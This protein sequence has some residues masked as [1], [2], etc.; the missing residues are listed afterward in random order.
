MKRKLSTALGAAA[1]AFFLTVPLTA[2][3]KTATASHQTKTTLNETRHR[4]WPA[5]TLS[6]KITMVDPAGKL[7]VLERSDGVSFDMIVTPSTRIR[8]GSRMLK[9]SG[10]ASDK[11]KNASVHF[12]PERRGDVAQSIQVTG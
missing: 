1:C 8:S 7:V 4:A 10:L 3:S 2:A 9:L 12:V 6:A 5:E 11:N